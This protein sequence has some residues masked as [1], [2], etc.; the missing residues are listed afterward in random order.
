MGQEDLRALFGLVE[1]DETYVGATRE[2]G[3]RGG[4]EVGN[5]TIVVGAVE[6]R[7]D[8]A[9]ALRLQ[10]L[11]GITFDHDLGPFV[12]QTIDPKR[13]TVRTDGLTSYR[14]LPAAGFHHDRQIEG[15]RRNA[16]E[17]LPWIHL[18]FTNLK[19]W[20]RGA[21]HGV[22]KKHMQ[23]Y[24]DEF[25]FRFDR[26]VNE[27]GLLRALLNRVARSEPY[28]YARLTAETIG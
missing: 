2:Q 20:I 26:R 23:R 11:E 10:V 15:H 9:G 3:L 22:S 6:H 13:A 5:K 4:R 1:V 21:F 7:D 28:P 27:Y 17:I 19:A 16:K 14:P 12:H 25:V 8:R 18:V 24:L